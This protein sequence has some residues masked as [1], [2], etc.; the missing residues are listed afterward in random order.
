MGYPVCP[1]PAGPGRAILEGISTLAN[2]RSHSVDRLFS[3]ENM[4]VNGPVLLR[5]N[6]PFSRLPDGQTFGKLERK[7]W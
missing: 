7:M 6:S 4:Y 1:G 3:M 2:S 5:V